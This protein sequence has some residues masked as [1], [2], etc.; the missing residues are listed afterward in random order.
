MLKN[1]KKFLALLLA[2]MMIL[3]LNGFAVL[4]ESAGE[5]DERTE[6]VVGEEVGEDEAE[7]KE[8]QSDSSASE[9]E[10]TDQQEKTESNVSS[11]PESVPSA[12]ESGTASAESTEDEDITSNAASVPE[13]LES[14][15]A[16]PESTPESVPA[17]PE[18]QA[19]SVQ[20][21]AEVTNWTVR[22]D[23]EKGAYITI[24]GRELDSKTAISEN[25]S[26]VFK[27]LPRE[28]YVVEKVFLDDGTEVRHTV[29]SDGKASEDEYILEGLTS[30]LTVHVKTKEK[31][32]EIKYQTASNKAVY[33]PGFTVLLSYGE[34]AKIPEDTKVKVREYKEGSGVYEEYFEGAVDATGADASRCEAKVIEVS[35]VDK[36]GSEL[37]PQGPVSVQIL[38]RKPV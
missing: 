14:V 9:T 37:E 31:P 24:N 28:G 7:K 27:A 30:D 36:N 10:G 16:A 2:V 29:G 25:G 19:E 17:A 38:F 22:F 4:A 33:G 1:V 20:S 23:L 32:E 3:S 12:P 35:F 18:S 11:V 34:D 15:P 21:V 6:S 13:T 5:A 26:L 8:T